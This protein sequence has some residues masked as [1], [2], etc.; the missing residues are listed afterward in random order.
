M[1]E[2]LGIGKKFQLNR[3]E[4]KGSNERNTSQINLE[5]QYDDNTN[6]ELQSN[7]R[8]SEISGTTSGEISSALFKPSPIMG[9][10]TPLVPYKEAIKTL[11]KIQQ[12]VTPREKLQCLSESFSYL[13]TAVVDFHKGK[14][15]TPHHFNCL[16]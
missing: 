12:C 11:E 7:I 1:M 13:K 16:L 10:E 2:S 14:V 4:A 9:S 6:R 8:Y 3:E 15:S 5:T